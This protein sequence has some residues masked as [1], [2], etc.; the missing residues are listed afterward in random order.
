MQ[1]R[2]IPQAVV[3]QVLT[4][5]RVA[6]VRGACIYAVGNREVAYWRARGVRLDAAS[7][8]QVV[9]D[10]G[11]GWVLTCFRNAD[12][13]SLRRKQR[14]RYTMP[15]DRG[16]PDNHC[17]PFPRIFRIALFSLLYIHLNEHTLPKRCT[18]FHKPVRPPWRN[19]TSST[20]SQQV[21]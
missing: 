10:P 14:Y 2:R 1:S 16:F 19:P 12:L 5:G 21:R 3:G 18:L 6:Y 20:R 9:V 11:T 7:G 17:R 13:R 4:Y 15:E 8:V